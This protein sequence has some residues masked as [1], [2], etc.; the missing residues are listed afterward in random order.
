[1]LRLACPTRPLG[2][3]HD[4]KGPHAQMHGR[5]RRILDLVVLIIY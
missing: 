3:L 5:I 2:D 1:V 4:T